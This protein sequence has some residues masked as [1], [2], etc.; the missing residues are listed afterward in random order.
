[1]TSL[2]QRGVS[3]KL[4][5]D[6]RVM[7]ALRR[8]IF[9]GALVA[10]TPLREVS[11]AERFG[12]GRYTVRAALAQLAVDG[13]VEQ[14]PNIGSRVRRLSATDVEDIY[15]VRRTLELAA[16]QLVVRRR[17]SLEGARRAA[18]RVADL[19]VS[20]L[21]RPSMKRRALDADLAFHRSAVDAAGSARLS[22]AYAT[23][24]AEVRLFQTQ[25]ITTAAVVPGEHWGLFEALADGDVASARRWID[26]HLRQGLRDVLR[27]LEA[28]SP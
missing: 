10:G 14:I 7:E 20:D 16:A 15:E 28:Q 1:V 2:A 13:L 3:R 22:R 26:G 19:E 9:E 23:I 17:A 21:S 12:V 6:R 25:L 18:E 11:L 24:L 4:S 8:E 27:A 5:A